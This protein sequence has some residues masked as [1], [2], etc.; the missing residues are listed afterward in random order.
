MPHCS[1]RVRDFA[2]ARAT[3][4]KV[5]EAAGQLSPGGAVLPWGCESQEDFELQLRAFRACAC[6]PPGA[7]IEAMAMRSTAERMDKAVE[8]LTE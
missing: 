2:W 3:V 8:L 6:F 7:R 1:C 4:R 5:A